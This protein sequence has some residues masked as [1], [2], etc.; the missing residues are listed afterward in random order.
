MTF[1]DGW[2]RWQWTSLPLQLA[3]AVARHRDGV[4]IRGQGTGWN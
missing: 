2:Q 1:L 3:E 4:I